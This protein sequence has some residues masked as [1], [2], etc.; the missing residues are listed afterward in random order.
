MGSLL[1]V[2]HGVEGGGDVSAKLFQVLRSKLWQHCVPVFL[3]WTP[4]LPVR[5][6]G[7][8]AWCMRAR[9]SSVSD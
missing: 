3:R 2:K 9:T 6:C 1:A 5:A 4:P 7:N 8:A